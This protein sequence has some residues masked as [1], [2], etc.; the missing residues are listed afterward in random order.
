VQA[1]DQVGLSRVGEAC[2]LASEDCLE[3][4]AVE[5]DIFHVE[6]LNGPVTGDSSG[7]HRVN[8]GRFYN[9]AEGLVVVDSGALSETPKDP[10]DLVAIKGPVSTELVREDSLAGDNVGALRLGNWLPGPIADQ[11]YVLFLHSRMP[12]GIGKCNTSGGGDRGQCRCR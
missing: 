9:R 3:E 5:E 7:E 4:S 6:L 11:G 10:T 2:G 12:M 8:S 1:T